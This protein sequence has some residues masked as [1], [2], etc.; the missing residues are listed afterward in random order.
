MR[1]HLLIRLVLLATIHPS[2]ASR[3]R[4]AVGARSLGRVQN[5]TKVL[6]A[7]RLDRSAYLQ[8]FVP[9]GLLFCCRR[10]KSCSYRT[11]TFCSTKME[12]N[13]VNTDLSLNILQKALQSDTLL[14][15]DDVHQAIHVMQL[16]AHKANTYDPD[17]ADTSMNVDFQVDI[18][19][20]ASDNT[21]EKTA[22]Q[23]E[24]LSSSG[25][26]TVNSLYQMIYRLGSSKNNGKKRARKGSGGKEWRA[27]QL[28]VSSTMTQN[29]VPSACIDKAYNITRRSRAVALLTLGT[30][31]SLQPADSSKNEGDDN[32]LTLQPTTKMISSA[33][34]T[35]L[36][37][38]VYED[39]GQ[40]QLDKQSE[41]DAAVYKMSRYVA[42][43]L[44]ERFIQQK[45]AAVDIQVINKLAH[46]FG[47]GERSNEQDDEL[48]QTISTV[49]NTVFGS[50]ILDED[51][52]NLIENAAIVKDTDAAVLSL[53]ASTRPWEAIAADRLVS[54]AAEHDLWFAAENICDAAIES[55]GVQSSGASQDT[56][57]AHLTTRAIIDSALGYRQYRRADHFATKYYT[58]GG[59]ERYA[60]ARYL[61]ACDTISKVIRK[62]VVQLIEKQVERVDSSVKRVEEDMLARSNGEELDT[63]S[64]DILSE[65]VREFSLRRLRAARMNSEALR[66]ARLWDMPYE[67]DPVAMAEELKH[68]KL[69][70]L[71]WDDEGLPGH[72]ADTRQIPLPQLISG[73][74]EL[75]GQFGILHN[76]NKEATIGFDCEWGDDGP[77]VALLQ[78]SSTTDVLLLDI[79]ALTAT[80]EGCDALRSTVGKLFSG[81]LGIKYVVGFSCKEDFSRLRASP[82]LPGNTGS[83]HWFPNHSKLKAEDLRHFI[84]ETHNLGSRG[85]P[86]GLSAACEHFLGKALDKSEQCSDWSMRPLTSEQRE[87]AAL[88]AWACAAIHVKIAASHK[89]LPAP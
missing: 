77:G 72:T 18:L 7:C 47:I 65:H 51:S 17:D 3:F 82:S 28:V 88:D 58:F 20:C 86:L 19:K 10:Q 62:K 63:S 30:I 50:R 87:Y 80:S 42:L 67:H 55:V 1:V 48:L 13:A 33:L 79:P 31:L 8:A 9:S 23:I 12:T 38:H 85:S 59:P 64:V 43:D 16:L 74:Q 27:M 57:V 52:G 66:L 54:I 84:F 4:L 2:S 11:T 53:V 36:A 21:E 81:A 70:Y 61:H 15:N 60:E 78:L 25:Y 39:G 22:N 49:V 26:T 83:K 75:I 56:S 5:R 41:E 14:S 68:R 6:P 46:G 24:M 37:K 35:D 71:Q 73:P 89:V 76:D 69:T 45:P 34:L 40:F 44:L 32:I 29:T